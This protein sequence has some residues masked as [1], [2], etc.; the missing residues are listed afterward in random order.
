MTALPFTG[1]EQVRGLAYDPAGRRL[2]VI[3]HSKTVGVPDKLHIL[4]FA[5]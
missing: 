1:F 3:N 2:F 5:S 4:P